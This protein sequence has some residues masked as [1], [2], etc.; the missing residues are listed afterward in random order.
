MTGKVPELIVVS[1][2]SRRSWSERVIL[3][4]P[5]GCQS[6]RHSVDLGNLPRDSNNEDRLQACKEMIRIQKYLR[7]KLPPSH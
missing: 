5:H 4:G 2:K 3:L 1:G 7:E 6:S